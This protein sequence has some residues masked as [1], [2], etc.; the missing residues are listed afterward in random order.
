MGKILFIVAIGLLYSSPSWAAGKDRTSVVFQYTL[1]NYHG[2][3]FDGAKPTP[4]VSSY[5]QLTN[6]NSAFEEKSVDDSLERMRN[7]L[8]RNI[9]LGIAPMFGPDGVFRTRSNQDKSTYVALGFAL[10][11]SAT[12]AA[13][14][15][16][17]WD[18]GGLSYGFGVNHSSF[19]IEYMIHMDEGIYDVSAV[20]MGLTSEF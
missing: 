6:I 5:G 8:G 3:G 2:D 4:A 13:G 7:A 17:G 10:D 15:S 16:N 19:N 1:A 20:S 12:D 18:D 11:G 9:D 14:T